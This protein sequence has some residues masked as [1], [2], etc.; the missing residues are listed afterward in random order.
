MKSWYRMTV[1]LSLAATPEMGRLSL[2]S[3][4]SLQDCGLNVF[5]Q[6]IHCIFPPKQA[7]HCIFS[8]KYIVPPPLLRLYIVSPP[9]FRVHIVSPLQYR[10]YIVSPLL[11]RVYIVSPLQCRLYI[12]SP[13]LLMLYIVSPP[14]LRLPWSSFCCCDEGIPQNQL[15]EEFAS[16]SCVTVRHCR[17]VK[18]GS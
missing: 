6:A 15:S 3:R 8:T 13:P 7:T 1:G 2:R 5:F 14:L 10:L 16:Q 11:C 12:V 18:A 9:L 17:E 4:F